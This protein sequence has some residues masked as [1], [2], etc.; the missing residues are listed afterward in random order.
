MEQTFFIVHAMLSEHC[1]CIICMHAFFSDRKIHFHH[2]SHT[3]F[4]AIKKFLCKINISFYR[5]IITLTYRIMNSDFIDIL[6]FCH[7]INCFHEHQA[8]T[9][10]VTFI[11]QRIRSRHKFQLT[12]SF[13]CL[14]QFLKSSIHKYQHNIMLIFLLICSGYLLICRSFFE[15]FVCSIY[16]DRI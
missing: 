8:H 15:F 3:A 13:Q 12:I 6:M 4:Y 2:S 1:N 10:P 14:E 9:S 16:M 11:T 7:I 5:A